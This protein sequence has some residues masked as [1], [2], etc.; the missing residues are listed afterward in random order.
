MSISPTD[1]EPY[2]ARMI[3]EARLEAFDN[4]RADFD[5]A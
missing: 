4:R 3:R 1:D 5:G 2:G